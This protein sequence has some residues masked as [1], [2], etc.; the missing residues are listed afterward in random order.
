MAESKSLLPVE[1]SVEELIQLQKKTPQIIFIDVR[2]ERPLHERSGEL[3]ER[4]LHIPF[5]DLLT[6][7]FDLDQDASIV[8]YCQSG[9]QGVHA[10]LYLRS[11]GFSHVQNLKGGLQSWHQRETG[12]IKSL[13][14]LRSFLF[15]PLSER[16]PLTSRAYKRAT[17]TAHALILDLE[18]SVTA[19]DKVAAR[20][21]LAEAVDY[22]AQI[23]PHILVR[24]NSDANLQ[25]DLRAVAATRALAVVLPKVDRLD[26][27]LQAR[28]FLRELQSLTTVIP[29]FETARGIL[30]CQTIVNGL[31]ELECVFFGSEDLAA[32]LR[33]T[34][35][36]PQNMLYAAQHLLLVCAAENISVVGAVGAFSAFHLK[37][38]L[39]FAKIVELSKQIGFSGSFAIHPHQVTTINE[40]FSGPSERARLQAIVD[41]SSDRQAVFSYDGRLYGPP[42]IKRYKQILNGL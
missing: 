5:S 22:F 26:Q 39:E 10:T 35:P 34:D 15:V 31:P 37:H 8:V 12:K 40:I 33:V 32:Q 14:D 38:R 29:L 41:Q 3:G 28:A 2:N 18:D 36:T 19:R 6:Q 20:G 24:V 17:A 11:L 9:E 21:L 7:S 42:M 4:A 27:L 30:N 13:R 1:I 23:N 25:A 16:R